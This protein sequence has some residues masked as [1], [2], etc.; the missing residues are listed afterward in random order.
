[1]T[2]D[3]LTKEDAKEFVTKADLRLFESNLSKQIALD[4]KETFSKMVALV[5]AMQGFLSAVIIG[6]IFFV[7]RVLVP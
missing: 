3:Y 6:S 4:S 2:K 7:V 1:M 5:F